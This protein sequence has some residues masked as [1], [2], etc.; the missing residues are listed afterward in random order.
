[1]SDVLL[2]TLEDG[3]LTLT[4]NRPERLNAL[5]PEMCERL[6]R[7][8][9]AAAVDSAVGAIV[10][11]GAGNAF[12]AG[13]DVK[14]MAESGASDAEFEARAADL[15]RRMEAARL[16][17][18]IPK[19]T[20][21]MLRGPAAGAG[22]SLAL[23]CDLRIAG[24]TARLTTAFAKVGL[25]GD[26]GGSYF[27]THLVGTAKARELYLL[28]PILDA[29][30]ALALGLV[31]RVVPDASLEAET[32]AL[33]GGLARGPRLTLGHIKQNLNLAE[34]ASLTEVMDVEALRHTRCTLTEDHREAAAA[35]VEKRKPVFTGR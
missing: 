9:H 26:F 4:L 17:H 6:Q 23:A 12:C 15:R 27:L 5:T 11:T 35:F 22:L 1:M 10:V 33:A 34:R 13:G 19:P 21:A 18:E 8:L 14:A 28:S 7:S 3:V 31:S 20:I 29:S 16:L 32:R 24:E 25:S 30:A 2:E